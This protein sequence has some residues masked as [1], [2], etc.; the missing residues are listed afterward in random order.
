M[1]PH[2]ELDDVT[3]F[4]KVRLVEA[5]DASRRRCAAQ[6]V[7]LGLG[8]V[9]GYIWPAQKMALADDGHEFDVVSR[10]AGML[11]S[12]PEISAYLETLPS[13]VES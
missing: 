5:D 8:E 7:F 10:M 3:G 6:G 12:D 13:G 1:I 11:M 2:E 9:L 4:D